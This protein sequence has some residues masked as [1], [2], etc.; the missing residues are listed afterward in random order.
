MT[1]W[2]RRFF[3]AGLWLMGIACIGWAVS[4]AS[5]GNSLLGALFGGAWGL[6][7]VGLAARWELLS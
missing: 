4:T 2:A 5:P 1:P 3:W 7:M 6:I